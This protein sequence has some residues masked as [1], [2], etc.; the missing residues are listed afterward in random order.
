MSQIHPELVGPLKKVPT[1]SFN[2]W[3]HPIG[4]FMIKRFT[5]KPVDGVI[6]ETVHHGNLRMRVFRP[7]GTSGPLPGLLWV[8][9]GGYIV[10]APEGDQKRASIFARDL[11]AI[12]VSP[13][14]RL[15]PK[16]PF[17]A[18]LD[19]L[20]SAWKWLNAHPDTANRLAIGGESAGGG[21]AAGLAQRLAD[22][23]ELP[24]PL[25]QLLVY[26]MLDDRT[27][28]RQDLAARKIPVW[29]FKSNHYGWSSYLGHEPGRATVADYAAP[30][31]REDLS[32]LAP[33]WIGVG[34]IDLFYDEDVDYSQ[35]LEAAGV[36]VTTELVPGAYHGF[37]GLA[38]DAPVSQRFHDSMV[39]FLRQVLSA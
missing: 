16:N 23:P 6:A 38:P 34:D 22:D 4:A 24:D 1:F 25:G 35:R 26:P 27:A 11:G 28:T 18:A 21:L 33:T 12:V 5:T 32:G 29:T 20:V 3:N 39:E 31:R 30:A 2:R 19:D 7:E 15:A 17:P 36:P 14:Y 10:G 9:G 13:A 37:P 8:H